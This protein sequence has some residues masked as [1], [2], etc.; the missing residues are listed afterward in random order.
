MFMSH[1]IV[2]KR[3]AAELLAIIWS[4]AV[5]VF[6]IIVTSA[7]AAEKATVELG[8]FG[9]LPVPHGWRVLDHGTLE[10][11]DQSS[12]W[13]VFQKGEKTEY[14]SF[15]AFGP[16]RSRITNAIYFTD[17]AHEIFPD[18]R[19]AGTI[20]PRLSHTGGPSIWSLRSGLVA[21]DG[22]EAL[23]YSFVSEFEA[24]GDNLLAHG[25]VLFGD[26]AMIVQHTS[27]RPNTPEFVWG[28]AAQTMRKLS[29]LSAPKNLKTK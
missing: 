20:K 14:L 28:V 8:R 9:P 24:G 29:K 15:Y 6:S 25:Y 5:F 7:T 26:F 19:I 21:L 2:G 23:E 10:N 27:D 13:V 17:T 3:T 11:G 12:H 1:K 22:Y 18:G 4:V 16:P